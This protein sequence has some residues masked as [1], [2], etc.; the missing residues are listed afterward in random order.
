MKN[1][2]YIL[3]NPP[4]NY[5]GKI[6]R[7][8]YAYEHHTVFWSAHGVVPDN[9]QCIHHKNSNSCD[10]SIDNLM[11]LS[12]KDHRILHAKMSNKDIEINC[13]ECKKLFTMRPSQYK[14]RTKRESLRKK[15]ALAK[16]RLAAAR[17]RRVKK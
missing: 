9:N 8:K 15:T 7:G 1:G 13:F 10:N 17:K 14:S 2:K 4:Q 16:K 12:K 11:L 6:Y 3:V 5:P